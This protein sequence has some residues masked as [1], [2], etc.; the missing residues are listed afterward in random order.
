MI[1]RLV[2]GHLDLDVVIRAVARSR[3]IKK[4]PTCCTEGNRHPK[5]HLAN[6]LRQRPA[7]AAP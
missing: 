1:R 7:H 6:A 2:S 5:E 3:I 4:P